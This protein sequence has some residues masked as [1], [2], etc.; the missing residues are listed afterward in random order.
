MSS[1]SLYIFIVYV[2]IGCRREGC[3]IFICTTV[4]DVY[5][6]CLSLSCVIIA[7]T[8]GRQRKQEPHIISKIIESFRYDHSITKVYNSLIL[9]PGLHHTKYFY[10]TYVN[11]S[12]NNI[13]VHKLFDNCCWWWWQQGI[14]C[15]A[16]P[17][18]IQCNH[19][20]FILSRWISNGRSRSNSYPNTHFAKKKKTR[21][22][23]AVHQIDAISNHF[24]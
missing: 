2:L 20:T 10:Y 17:Q 7:E 11:Y 3:F 5:M 23:R 14:R 13:F 6:Y 8:K 16:I 22:Q 15:S 18:L 19:T 24:R 9:S 1:Q 12:V 4:D 21:H